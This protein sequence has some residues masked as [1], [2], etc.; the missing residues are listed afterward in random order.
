MVGNFIVPGERKTRGP[1][2]LQRMTML[3]LLPVAVDGEL[4]MLGRGQ[5]GVELGPRAE[6]CLIGREQGEGVQVMGAR[7]W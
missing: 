6:A 4:H 2:L 5:E 3:S 7:T 1:R